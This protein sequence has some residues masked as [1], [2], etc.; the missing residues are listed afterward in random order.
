MF[1]P[2]VGKAFHVNRNLLVIGQ[3]ANGWNPKWFVKNIPSQADRII[4]DSIENSS[5]ENGECPLEWINKKWNSYKLFRSFFWNVTYKLV[6]ETYNRTDTDWNNIIAWT[7]LMKISPADYGNPNNVERKA[8]SN[9]CAKLFMQELKDLKPKNVLIITNLDIWAEP[10]LKQANIEIKN[11]DG[12]YIQ[13]TGHFSGSK[14]IVTR[15]PFFGRHQ[16]FIK[17]VGNEL[18]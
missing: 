18:E 6:K 3:A 7:N 10:I 13:A 17:E 1:Y 11:V 14:I 15:R 8:Q 9:N 12:N 5:E 16:P 4:G 2:S